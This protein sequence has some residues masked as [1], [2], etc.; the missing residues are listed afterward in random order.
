VKLPSFLPSLQ[1]LMLV[2]TTV[3]ERVWKLCHRN[4]SNKVIATK[5][6]MVLVDIVCQTH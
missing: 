6:D 4:K 5:E 2:I 1:A 3:I